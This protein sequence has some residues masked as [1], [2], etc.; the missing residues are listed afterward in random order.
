MTT[1]QMQGQQVLE[2]S[3]QYSYAEVNKR[4]SKE[5]QAKHCI[6]AISK[7]GTNVRK[8]KLDENK[9]VAAEAEASRKR[10]SH[11]FTETPLEL[12]IQQAAKLQTANDLA[13]QSKD[14]L[15]H[16][17][18]METVLTKQYWKAVPAN[19]FQEEL[20]NVFPHFYNSAIGQM[21]KSFLMRS[22]T[23]TCT[24]KNNLGLFITLVK[25]IADGKTKNTLSSRTR[26]QQLKRAKATKLD[27]MSEFVKI[28]ESIHL[29]VVE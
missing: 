14:S 6:R 15:D 18:R 8:K 7:R 27:L 29:S 28:E 12:Q 9:V 1:Q 3:K 20:R 23:G 21:T 2:M 25:N 24:A 5:W 11:K 26:V 10:H 16:A 22:K 4:T 13:W 19:I 17:K